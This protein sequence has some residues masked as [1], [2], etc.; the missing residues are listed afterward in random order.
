MGRGRCPWPNT[1]TV[2]EERLN[3]TR[4]GQLL[5]EV[6]YKTE[7]TPPSD[8]V[9]VGASLRQT[10]AFSHFTR[11]GNSQLTFQ[12][13]RKAAAFPQNGNSTFQPEKTIPFSESITMLIKQRKQ[14]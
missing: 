14:K 1:K 5:Y 10:Q 2:L 6:F 8:T 11:W 13:A 9:L 7:T 12:P 3:P 4:M